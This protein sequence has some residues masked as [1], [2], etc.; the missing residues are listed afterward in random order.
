MTDFPLAIGTPVK[1]TAILRRP[2]AGA[3]LALIVLVA[4]NVA[5]TPNF[6]TWANLW[7]ILWQMSAVAII[8]VGM[9]MV[10]ATGGIDL[11]V[12]SVMALAG[13]VAAVQLERGAGSAILIALLATGAIGL[14][15][16]AL[17]S[18]ADRQP[19]VVTLAMLIAVRGLAQVSSHDGQLVPIREGAF[20]VLGR[21][22]IGPVPGPVLVAAMVVIAAIIV[23]RSTPFGRYLLAVGGNRSAA[24][25]AGVPV[26]RVVIAAYLTNA[27]LAGL[28]GLLEA[29][30]IGASDAATMGRDI[31][32]DAIAAA[33]VGGTPLTG[34]RASLAGTV[35]GALVMQIVAT[36]VNMLLI[37]YSWA[38][39]LKA[40]I[41]VVAVYLQRPK[42][43]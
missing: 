31:E 19:I 35:V 26:R 30:R 41:L 29:A 17:L 5:F 40:M 4:F 6:A 2:A 1:S 21:G 20:T 36:T 3:W 28:A 9:T 24:A 14:I 12:G 23:M 42:R 43:V 7:N 27:L 11:S 32:L 18:R 34:G 8:G 16:G 15:N 22:R 37:P 25:L 39:V 10:I 33:V 38:L 13:A